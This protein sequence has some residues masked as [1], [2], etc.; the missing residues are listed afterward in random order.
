[1][2]D[3]AGEKFIKKTLINVC[4]LLACYKQIIFKC[5]NMIKIHN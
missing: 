4:Y 5:I 3:R 1:M 2:K